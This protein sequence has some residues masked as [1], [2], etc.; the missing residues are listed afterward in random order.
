M[1]NHVVV[2]EID[3][4]PPDIVARLG[5]AGVATAHEAAGRTGL[6]DRA[7]RPI[8]SGGAVAGTAVTVS[9]HP[10]D[11]LMIH[12][13][14]EQLR[15]GDILVVSTTSPSTD[16][17]IGELLAVSMAWHGARAVVTD[18]GVRDVAELRSMNFPIWARAIS[19]QGTVKATPGSVNVPVVCGGRSITPGDVIVA[20][21]DGIVCIPRR[22]A[23]TVAEAAE[24]RLEKE[25]R[26]RAALASGALGVD[27]YGLRELALSLGV[28]YIR[29]PLAVAEE[30]AP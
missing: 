11:N 3:R 7:L 21:D 28:E 4:T 14:V 12:L 18:A 30:V 6:L 20:D 25:S 17:M 15:D 23:T 19:A 27:L 10:G 8:L 1:K 9:S 26:T 2:E 16:G 13:A 5:A 24:A 22:L 29:Q